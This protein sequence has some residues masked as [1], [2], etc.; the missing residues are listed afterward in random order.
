METL[1]GPA[2]TP[3]L[4]EVVKNTGNFGW[5]VAN[6]NHEAAATYFIHILPV[7]DV[8]TVCTEAGNSASFAT[9]A[10]FTLEP[11]LVTWA[12]P[13]PEGV[14][15]EPGKTNTIHIENVINHARRWYGGLF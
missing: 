1:V 6:F 12:W 11:Q 3:V 10:P 14:A 5:I 7:L 9:T 13:P 4:D 8:A 2:S 15:I